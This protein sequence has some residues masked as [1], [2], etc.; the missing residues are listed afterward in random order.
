VQA[1]SDLQRNQRFAHAALAGLIADVSELVDQPHDIG[2]D[3]LPPLLFALDKLGSGLADHFRAEEASYLYGGLDRDFPFLA[4]RLGRLR[5]EHGEMLAELGAA[6][7]AAGDG[8]TSGDAVRRI[9]IRVHMLLAKLHRHEAE[10]IEILLSAH[11]DEERR[12]W[13]PCDG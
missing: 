4:S 3:W 8:V 10:E 11:W 9:R 1:I 13:P 12:S 7:D 2:T 5:T 6:L